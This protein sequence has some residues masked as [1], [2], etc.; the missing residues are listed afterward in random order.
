MEDEEP[1]H[2]VTNEMITDLYNN[3]GID[4]VSQL[5]DQLVDELSRSIDKKIM[6]ELFSMSNIDKSKLIVDR[7]IRESIINE[8]NGNLPYTEDY[9][10]EITLKELSNNNLSSDYG[11]SS[12]KI[13]DY[14]KEKRGE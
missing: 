8:L 14:I 2:E 3:H 9:I 5:E 13:R 10:I 1:I 7:L 12:N 11:I 4:I 6:E